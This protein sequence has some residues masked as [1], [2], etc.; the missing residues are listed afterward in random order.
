MKYDIQFMTG[1]YIFSRNCCWNFRRK[2]QILVQSAAYNV[3][4]NVHKFLKKSWVSHKFDESIR[5][6]LYTKVEFLRNGHFLANLGQSWLGSVDQRFFSSKD[7]KLILL[8]N[9]ERRRFFNWV[10]TSV[11][12]CTHKYFWAK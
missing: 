11:R 7:R 9:W 3:P 10:Q 5:T 1:K 4:K 12:L 2:N 6:W 8:R